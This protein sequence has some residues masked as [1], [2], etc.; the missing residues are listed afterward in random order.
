MRSHRGKAQRRLGRGRKLVQHA[1]TPV[2]YEAY[3]H[4]DFHSEHRGVR[5]E[6]ILAEPEGGA[7]SETE[8]L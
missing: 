8:V 3:R 5:Q 2:S 6:R 7:R 1:G 4:G